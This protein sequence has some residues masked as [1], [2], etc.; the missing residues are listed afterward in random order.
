MLRKESNYSGNTRLFLQ[1][2]KERTLNEIVSYGSLHEN[3]VT[4][5]TRPTI[6]HWVHH[7][8]VTGHLEKHRLYDNL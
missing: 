2:P 4:L 5:P 8:S 3:V 6:L 1:V 7:S